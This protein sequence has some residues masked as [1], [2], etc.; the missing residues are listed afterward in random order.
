MATAR[1]AA[2]C[3]KSRY[4]R[5]VIAHCGETLAV[6]RLGSRFSP[7]LVVAAAAAAIAVEQNDGDG[8][9]G[10]GGGGDDDDDDARACSVALK[11]VETQR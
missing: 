4:L 7:L 5:L 3:S 9:G 6:V 1:S 11:C 8:G 2:R 10:G